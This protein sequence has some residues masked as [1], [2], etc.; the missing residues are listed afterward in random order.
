MSNQRAKT[1][2]EP[3]AVKNT[4]RDIKNRAVATIA[5]STHVPCL[6]AAKNPR[7]IP[8]PS[9]MIMAAMASWAETH[10]RLG[11]SSDTSLPLYR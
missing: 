1:T 2:R 4:G 7:G 10:M 3:G 6:M 9:E 8:K 11:N 5:G